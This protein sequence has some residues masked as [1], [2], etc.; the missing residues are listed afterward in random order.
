MPTFDDPD[1]DSAGSDS[2]S[3]HE[4]ETNQEERD[5]QELD[6]EADGEVDGEQEGDNEEENAD[7]EEEQDSQYSYS[8]TTGKSVSKATSLPQALPRSNSSFR[9]VAEG[10]KSS[11]PSGPTSAPH[12]SMLLTSPS[13]TQESA[14]SNGFTFDVPKLRPETVTAPIYD[15]VPTIAAPHGT[16]INAITATSDLRWVFSG[17]AD[18]YIRRYNW[19]E[20]ANGKSQLTVAQKHP[21]VDSVTK[22]GVLMNYWENNEDTSGLSNSLEAVE[23]SVADFNVSTGK[24]LEDGSSVSPVYSLAAQHEGLWLLSGLES[25]GINLSSVR[26]DE[27]KQITCLKSH[28]S[29]V[30]VLN[31]S[32]DERS[33][34][35]GSWDKRVLNWD[36]NTGQ[37]IRS[38]EGSGGQISAL[39]PRPLSSLP[40]PPTFDEVRR[41]SETM[42]SD[43]ADPPRAN[44]VSSDPTGSA[45]DANTTADADNAVGAPS[46]PADSLFDGGSLFGDNENADVA[47]SGNNFVDE[48]DDFSKAIVSNINNDQQQESQQS[49]VHS[50]PAD[51]NMDMSL[52]D[53]DPNAMDI[54][55]RLVDDT[56][57]ATDILGLRPPNDED[58]TMPAKLE[59]PLPHGEDVP[60]LNAVRRD[61]EPQPPDSTPVVDSVFLAASRDGSVRVWDKRQPQPVAKMMPKGVPPWCMNATWSPDGN[62][63]FA[64]RRNGSVDEY[65]LHKGLGTCSRSLKLPSGSGAVSAVRAMP[66]GRHLL[67]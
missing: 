65:S 27:G 20:T 24:T 11:A 15:V 34:L 49:H 64:G 66:N 67:T 60:S 7:E 56:G 3:D 29:A 26:V 55:T 43:N 36:L 50:L 42:K 28:T 62:F 45:G 48:D 40:V 22:A 4:Q 37:V 5:E 38:F 8:G 39:E 57:K 53:G 21:F 63:L 12:P 35:S 23:I 30:S 52:F 44:G 9:S 47:P 2:S 41:E 46:S 6:A 51:E 59:D 17:G 61:Q 58:S 25:G 32:Q 33:L 10:S 16:S 54:D 14:V 13:P 1:K 18:G 31:L 19:I